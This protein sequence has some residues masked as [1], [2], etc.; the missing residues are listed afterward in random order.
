MEKQKLR[1][2]IDEQYKWDLTPI[3]ANKEV[4][5][6]DYT[7]AKSLIEEIKNYTD[8]LSS[9][10]KLYDFLKYD[11][12]V[13]RLVYKLY[14][15][16]HLNYDADTLNDD[17]QVMKR[18][19]SDLMNHQNELSAFVMPTFL[20]VD[21]KTIL[22]YIE[23]KPELKEYQF[24]LEKLY[25]NKEHVLSEKE[26]EMLSLLNNNLANPSNTYEIL[27]DSDLT[28]GTI[29]DEDGNEV[30]L[31]ESNYGKYTSSFNRKV[32]KQAF[33]KL[34]DTFAN[35]KNTITSTYLGD[36][37]AN[38]SLAKIRKYPSALEASLHADNIDKKV[39]D[40]LIS[41][42]HDNLDVLY[43]YYDLKKQVLKL[44]ELHLY[45]LHVPLI[46]LKK[47]QY[48]FEEA[49]K[50]VLDVVKILGDD[51]V[52]IIKKEFNEKWIDVY[53]NKGKRTG[54]YSSGFYDTNPYILLNYEGRLE[55]VFTLIHESGHSAHTYLSCHNNSY[56]NSSYKIFVAEVASITNELLLAKYLLKNSNSKEE[57]LNVLN[58]LLELFKG[59]IYR[60]TMFAEFEKKMYDYRE[61]GN[62]I[63]SEF[64]CNEYYKL[65]KLY[66]G[67]K[68][69]VDD[70]IRYEWERV[71]HFYYNFYVYKYSIGLSAAC[72]IVEN[73]ING[74]E[75]AVENYKSFLKSGGSMYPI[76]ELKIAGVDVSKKEVVESA[77]RMFKETIEQFKSLI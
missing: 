71:P 1:S 24:T 9:S 23:E 35:F 42:I 26:E 53:N 22:Q 75:N 46:Q 6:E 55:D 51:Y 60:Q 74:K 63:T 18:K 38:I 70:S 14:Y 10:S 50:I 2:E 15:Y 69:V 7:R 30:E 27:T 77:V 43:D 33:E 48:D 64:L 67:E 45:D 16:A 37:D 68:V 29:H 28:F 57:K 72:Y 13:E 49:K 66:F 41:T 47:Q 3:Y 54:A 58:R 8:F 34:Y 19:I 44:D 52:D 5:Y 59:T 12:K 17:Y 20:K 4:W 56:T 21:F 65:N 73:I 61:S 11:E 31:T 76:D 39:Y 36:M 40:N 25:R 62:V 32:R